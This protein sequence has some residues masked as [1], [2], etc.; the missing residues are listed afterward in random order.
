MGNTT[1]GSGARSRRAGK[2][3][4]LLLVAAVAVTVAALAAPR[5]LA[6]I[7]YLPVDRALAQYY[8]T[9]EIPSDRLNVLIRFA[10]EAIGY[11][12]Y[13]RYRDG[14]SQLHYLRGLDV[15]TPAGERREAYRM[16]E[17]EAENALRQAPAQPAVWLRLATIRWILHDEP[18]TIVTPWKMSVFTGRTHSSLYTHRVEIGLAYRAWLES[19]GLAMLRD[20]MRLAWKARPGTLIRVLARR[21]PGLAVTRGLLR[22]GDPDTLAEMEAWLERLR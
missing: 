11:H 18:E 10:D 5:V 13:F 9:N 17:A 3:A 16:A 6:S 7:R 14:L 15:Q 22:G 8:T 20:Q 21:D 4:V 19:E 1:R 12:D 2:L